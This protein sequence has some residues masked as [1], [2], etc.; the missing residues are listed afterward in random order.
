MVLWRGDGDCNPMPSKIETCACGKR[1][2]R[3]FSNSDQTLCDDCRQ[4][5]HS[6]DE[7]QKNNQEIQRVKDR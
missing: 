3:G 7:T 1:F 2:L 4:G 6:Q 5:S